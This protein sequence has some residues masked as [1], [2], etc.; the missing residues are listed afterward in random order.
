MN[1]DR[2][3]FVDS[4]IWLYAFIRT[5]DPDKCDRARHVVEGVRNI[6]VS[7]QVVNEVSV[8]LLKKGHVAEEEIRDIVSAFYRKYR[9]I[10]LDEAVLNDASRLREEHRFSFWDSLIVSA[11]FA[12]GVPVLYTEDMQHGRLVGGTLRIVNPFLPI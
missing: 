2:G 9:V 12:S 3:C 10:P 5:S 4:N 1:A 11:A 8:N 7:I 6:T